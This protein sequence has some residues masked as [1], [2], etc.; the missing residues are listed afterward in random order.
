LPFPHTG[1]FYLLSFFKSFNMKFVVVS[2]GEYLAKGSTFVAIPVFF[3]SAIS[4][5]W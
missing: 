1:T 5:L 2:G 3:F 4:K